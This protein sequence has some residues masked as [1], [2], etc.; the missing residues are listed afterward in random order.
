MRSIFQ[1]QDYIF[2]INAVMVDDFAAY[3][4]VVVIPIYCVVI[5]I[6]TI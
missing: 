1:N 4:K 6:Q 5:V 2:S 3:I